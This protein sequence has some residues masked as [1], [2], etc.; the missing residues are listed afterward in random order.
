[1]ELKIAHLYPEMLNLY[2][3][4]GN[5]ITL[6]ERISKRGIEAKIKEYDISEKIEF[7]DIDIIYIGGG[8][9][10]EV[11]LACEKLCETKAEFKS[12]AEDG[13]TILAVAS[14]YPLLGQYY[15]QDGEKIEALQLMDMYTEECDKRIIGNII[16]ESELINSTIVG[17]ENHSGRTYTQNHTPLGKV[18]YG[19][20]N[21]DKKNIEGAVYK[22]VIGTYLHGPLLPKNPLLADYII[23]NALFKKYGLNELEPID[24]TIENMA[25]KYILDRYIKK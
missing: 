19:Y 17:F 22:N 2:G 21:S 25:H 13:G 23:K 7:S 4:I 12:F 6:K 9:D 20:G 10:R 16:L 18:I 3:D 11:R 14:G 5:I 8:T 1:M 24:D 15:M